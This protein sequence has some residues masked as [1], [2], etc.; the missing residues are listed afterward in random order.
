L[1]WWW[2]IVRP[3]TY[4]KEFRTGFQGYQVSCKILNEWKS[5][6]DANKLKGFVI[7]QDYFKSKD[8]SNNLDKVAACAQR[9]GFAILDLRDLF[10]K[11]SKTQPEFYRSLWILPKPGVHLSPVGNKEKAMWLAHQIDTFRFYP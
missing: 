10:G 1:A 3:Q 9:L 11:A 2:G 4:P 8:F 6:L 5:S 7:I